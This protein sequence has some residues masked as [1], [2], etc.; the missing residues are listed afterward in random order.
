MSEK[1]LSIEAFQSIQIDAASYNGQKTIVTVEQE[2]P[3]ERG[4][5]K[6]A[7]HP[8]EA[9]D[10]GLKA[11][12]I[13]LG[14][15]LVLFST[16]GFVN[17]WGVF[18]EYYEEDLLR[19]TSPSN[20]AWIGSTQYALSY[21]P[22]LASGRMF[23]LGYFKIPFYVAS[24]TLV[25][26]TFLTAECTQFW[27]FFLTQGVGIGLCS[28]TMFAPTVIIVSQ[29]FSRR[30]GLAMAIGAVGTPLG[31][32]VLPVA[33]Q[34]LIP[35]IG[36][37]WTVRVFGFIM[38]ATLGTANLMKRRLPPVNVH[39][40]LFN[41]KAFRNRA[42]TMYCIS[43]I[44]I[45]LGLYTGTTVVLVAVAPDILVSSEL[46]YISV[47][48]VAIGVSKNFAFYILAIAN[49][50]STLRVSFGLIADKIGALNTMAV[51]TALAGIMTIAWPFA[52]NESQLIAIAATYGYV[53]HL[54][55]ARCLTH[56]SRFSTGAY[57]TLCSIPAV[58][59]GKMDD[60]GR[61][62]GMFLS[63]IGLG[64]IAGPPISGAISTATGGFV[65]AGYFAG[66]SIIFGV[67][68]LLVARYLHLG[69]LWGKF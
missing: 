28:G 36:F 61:R 60:A 47:S 56:P 55:T 41:L 13:V 37:R 67:L 11:W 53:L 32:I 66:G 25:A 24:C 39:G 68:L 65:A 50:A 26:C 58:A 35:L 15:A 3:N 5:Q 64:G 10:G 9:P 19:H 23:D 17:S 27:Q 38:I 42:Y 46:T 1:S 45:V 40:G 29:W 12:F 52:K 2:I 4:S 21:L 33:A 8:S 34:N 51:L 57:V 69:R 18:Q 6:L 16:L 63:L 59:M 22:S 54:F 62:V 7:T 49:A 31:S 48:A 20:I 44:M 43:G 14:A 30:R